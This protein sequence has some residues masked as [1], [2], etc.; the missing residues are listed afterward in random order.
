MFINR[1]TFIAGASTLWKQVL[2][3]VFPLFCLG[4]K[5]TGFLI[6]HQCLGQL[7]LSHEQRCPQCFI[8]ITPCGEVCFSCRD[9]FAP[10]LDGLFVASSYHEPLLT[11]AIHTY[12]YRFIPGL[13]IPLGQL[14][15]NALERSTLPLPDAII[16]VPLHKRRLRFRGFNQSALLAQELSRALVPGF[17]IPLL[18]HALLRTRFTKPQIKTDSREERLNNLKNAFALAPD[19]ASSL[20]G[21]YIWL[22]DDVATTGT[23]LEECA[24]VLKKHGVTKVFGIVLAH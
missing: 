17:D 20:R 9:T 18:S 5:R 23:T 16:P 1:A 8:H 4:C 3:T 19:M 15:I 14:L 12:K 6:C 22:I 24:R 10:P 2:D 13:A 7:F 11:R 21:K